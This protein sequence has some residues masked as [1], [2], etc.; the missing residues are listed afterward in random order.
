LTGLNYNLISCPIFGEYYIPPSKTAFATAVT[1]PLEAIATVIPSDI[2]HLLSNNNPTVNHGAIAMAHC[3]LETAVATVIPRDI[4]NLLRQ[5]QF[6][7]E[8][9]KPLQWPLQNRN[10]HCNGD[11]HRN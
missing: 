6:N 11:S 3:K 7:G 8:S 2:R 4:R 5:Q 10:R 1:A 9:T